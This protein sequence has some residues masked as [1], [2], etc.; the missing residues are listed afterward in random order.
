MV[1]KPLKVDERSHKLV[2]L[3]A[4]LTGKGVRETTIAIIAEYFRDSVE[5][6]ILNQA[7]VASAP[8]LQMT[9]KTAGAGGRKKV[10][11]GQ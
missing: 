1:Y 8:A 10:A 4:D 2:K 7:E 6:G 11:T 3:R 9:G 5:E